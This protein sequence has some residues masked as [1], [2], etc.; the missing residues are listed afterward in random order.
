[1]HKDVIGDIDILEKFSFVD[2]NEGVVSSLIAKASGKKLCGRR[3]NIEI[4]NRNK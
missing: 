4:A 1:V 2:I 3:V